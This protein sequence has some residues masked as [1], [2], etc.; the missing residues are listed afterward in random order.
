MKT[1]A[2]NLNNDNFFCPVTGQ[3]ILGPETYQ[4]SPTLIGVWWYDNIQEPELHDIEL[5]AE[6]EAFRERRGHFQMEEFWE[7]VQNESWVA[8]ILTNKGEGCTE[9]VTVAYVFN[10]N[11]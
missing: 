1:L 9:P 2:L 3:R 6:W 5:L 11:P 4:R 10:T 7:S 8:F